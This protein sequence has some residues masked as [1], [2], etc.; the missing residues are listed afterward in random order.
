MYHECDRPN[1]A[2]DCGALEAGGESCF[3]RP[4]KSIPHSGQQKL[5][6]KWP[7]HAAPGGG[8]QA[9]GLSWMLSEDFVASNLAGLKRHEIDAWVLPAGEHR[10]LR[11]TIAACLGRSVVRDSIIDSSAHW[12]FRFIL[13]TWRNVQYKTD[14]LISLSAL[15]EILVEFVYL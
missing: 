10:P 13:D 8:L 12:D 4:C 7:V 1:I 14:L 9:S 15:P 2:P 11:W 6:P 5:I 3:D